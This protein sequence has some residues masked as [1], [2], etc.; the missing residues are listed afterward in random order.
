MNDVTDAWGAGVEVAAGRLEC[1]NAGELLIVTCSG[2]QCTFNVGS[3]I[4]MNPSTVV[5]GL[6]TRLL[7]VLSLT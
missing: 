2:L 7:K 5:V 4:D 1:R 3:F 6:R